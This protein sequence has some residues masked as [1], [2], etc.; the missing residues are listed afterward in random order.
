MSSLH[1]C[2]SRPIVTCYR[3]LALAHEQIHV[4]S[5]QLTHINKQ[6]CGT[7][8]LSLSSRWPWPQRRGV[9]L[10]FEVA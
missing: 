1:H 7:L 9:G 4:L 10:G 2:I 6:G 3:L 5:Y 8:G